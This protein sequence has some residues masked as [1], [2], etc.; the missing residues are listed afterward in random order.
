MPTP[1]PF[2]INKG[3]VKLNQTGYLPE[4]QK[5]SRALARAKLLIN[6]C[7]SSHISKGHLNL[8]A[9]WRVAA[10]VVSKQPVKTPIWGVE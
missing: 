10:A 3:K 1:C 7:E 2:L 6:K 9:I 4:P 8:L 5:H